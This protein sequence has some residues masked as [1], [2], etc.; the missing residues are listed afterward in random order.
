MHF[1]KKEIWGKKTSAKQKGIDL[2][3]QEARLSKRLVRVNHDINEICIFSFCLFDH[4]GIP[5]RTDS[6]VTEN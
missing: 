2:F 1:L 3:F 4:L 5:T 6:R